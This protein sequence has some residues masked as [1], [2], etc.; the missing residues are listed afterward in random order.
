MKLQ[1]IPQTVKDYPI[2]HTAYTHTD[3]YNEYTF[4]GFKV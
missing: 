1:Y 2:I 3:M 4:K